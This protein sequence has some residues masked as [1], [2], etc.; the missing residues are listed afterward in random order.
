MWSQC[1]FLF[2]QFFRSEKYYRNERI[3][4]GYTFGLWYQIFVSDIYSI[5]MC[6][7]YEV[8]RWR[9]V[10][11]IIKKA[12]WRIHTWN[13]GGAFR[14]AEDVPRWVRR[15]VKYGL[16]G[17]WRCSWERSCGRHGLSH[18]YM[19]YPGHELRHSGVDCWISWNC[20][21]HVP[22]YDSNL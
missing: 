3:C 22:R 4:S 6:C 21:A 19:L 8:C 10:S 9:N 2:L 12:V 1:H 14:K 11:T 20:T 18:Y 5:R 13:I 16:I 7:V 17:R 15:I